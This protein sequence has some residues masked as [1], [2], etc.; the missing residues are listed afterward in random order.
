MY[1]GVM[2]LLI[3]YIYMYIYLYIFI[4]IF[5]F[6]FIYTMYILFCVKLDLVI[7]QVCTVSTLRQFNRFLFVC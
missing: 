2:L 4:Y 6:V 1:C 3:I 5:M 7:Y